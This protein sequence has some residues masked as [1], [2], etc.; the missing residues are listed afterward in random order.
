MQIKVHAD[1]EHERIMRHINLEQMSR[2]A[3]EIA[4]GAVVATSEAAANEHSA[5]VTEVLA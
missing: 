2:K 1:L 5:N 3:I 4:Q